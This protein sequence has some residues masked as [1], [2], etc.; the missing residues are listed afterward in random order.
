MNVVS[1]DADLGRGRIQAPWIGQRAPDVV[2]AGPIP[3]RQVRIEE[4]PLPRERLC[5]ERRGHV[6]PD[7]LV[8]AATR[9]SAL[10]WDDAGRIAVGGRADLVAVRTDGVRPSS[11][12]AAPSRSR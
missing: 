9:H 12:L 5:V 1:N 3:R 7:E 10:G 11:T 6:T 4:L 8:A 2:Q